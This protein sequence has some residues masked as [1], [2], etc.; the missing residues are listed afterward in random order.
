MLVD[1]S[2]KALEKFKYFYKKIKG[3]ELINLDNSFIK[4]HN[5]QTYDINQ[6][7]S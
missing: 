1:T 6:E 5:F 2:N 7:L 3:K 4:V